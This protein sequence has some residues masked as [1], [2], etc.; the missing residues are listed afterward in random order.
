MIFSA[1]ANEAKKREQEIGR[2]SHL[3]QSGCRDLGI[4]RRSARAVFARYGIARI[5]LV[6]VERPN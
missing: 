1:Y 6:Y 4:S 3:V 2:A 5:Y